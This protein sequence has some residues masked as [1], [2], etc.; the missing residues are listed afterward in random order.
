MNINNLNLKKK[1]F[2][3]I[4]VVLIV[5]LIFLSMIGFNYNDI[6]ATDTFKQLWQF[7]KDLGTMVMICISWIGGMF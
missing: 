7:T 2:V 1:G 6:I 4:I 3:E 5:A